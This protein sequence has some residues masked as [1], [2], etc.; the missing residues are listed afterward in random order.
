M[1]ALLTVKHVAQ[2]LDEHPKTVIDRIYR[3]E[4]G[5]VHN[6]RTGPARRWRIPQAEVDR[7][8]ASWV[9]LPAA[10]P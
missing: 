9:Q 4:L 2:L 7:Y 1:T 3:G 5:G 10:G 6:G 8:V